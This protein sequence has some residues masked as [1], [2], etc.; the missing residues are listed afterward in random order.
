MFFYKFK[1]LLIFHKIINGNSLLRKSRKAVE[2]ISKGDKKSARLIIATIE[3]YSRNPEG[4][5]DIKILK[6]KMGEFRR[7]R[8]GN[9]RIIFD[10]DGNILYIYEVKH[11]QGVY[12]D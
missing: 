10:D 8:V 9:Y 5:F 7:L 4:S 12:N 2:K 6:G 3:K 1:N 11:R